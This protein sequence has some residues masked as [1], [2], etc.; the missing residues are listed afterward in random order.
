MPKAH[1]SVAQTQELK[2]WLG[3]S[4]KHLFN[5]V[6]FNDIM[7]AMRTAND[8]FYPYQWNLSAAKLQSAWDITTGS[9]DIVVAVVDSGIAPDHPDVIGRLAQGVDLIEDVGTAGDGNGRD[10][11]PTDVGDNMFGGG[12]HSYHG[13]HVAGVIGAA[14][15]NNLGITGMM[16]SGKNFAG[17]SFRTGG[18]TQFDILSGVYW[19]LGDDEVSGV[20]ENTTPAR[21]VNLSL[22]GTVD[23]S[24]Y[25]AWQ[26]EIGYIFSQETQYGKPI[27]VAAAGNED[28]DVANV[29]PANID[30]IITVGAFKFDGMRANYS[31]WGQYVDIMAPGGQTD[32][33]QN[34]DG[35]PDGIYSFYGTDYRWEHG[36]SMATPHVA[37]ILGLAL[38]VN[39][40]LNQVQ[41]QQLIYDTADQSGQCNEGCGA[42][43]VNAAN[44][45]M[46]VSGGYIPE[47]NPRLAID[48]D[49]VIF[50]QEQSSGIVNIF[51]LGGGT[52]AYETRIQGVN[53]DLFS[54][55]PT[56]GTIEAASGVTLNVTLNRGTLTEG[57]AELIVEGLGESAGQMK[58]VP[59][60]F[61]DVVLAENNVQSAVVEAFL[62]LDDGQI[63]TTEQVVYA[64]RSEGFTW[65]IDG[66]TAGQ[67]YVFAVGDDNNDGVYD[68]NS[69]SFGAYPNTATPKPITV[70]ANQ[71]AKGVNFALSFSTGSISQGGW[72]PVPSR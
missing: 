40:E 14:S 4:Y 22:G 15:D 16:W 60:S 8:T 58:V 31:N 68:S 72:Y 49:R 34:G 70:T 10:T 37:G 13:S 27:I 24:T 32:V 62:V 26:G 46:T 1:L 5:H 41:A 61:R 29:T 12:Q 28:Q 18:G 35:Q 56:S 17:T 67:Y 33:D 65:R 59:L 9:D 7:Q 21:I 30:S 71:L 23:A 3:H 43:L 11:D 38:A 52:L 55:S 42:G 53:A 47:A 57:E 39:P 6:T 36:T 50:Y 64:R 19:A 54:V 45:L 44:L 25:E 20:P 69:E 2:Y 66:L 63:E 51:N 48:S